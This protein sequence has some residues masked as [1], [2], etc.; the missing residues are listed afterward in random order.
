MALQKRISTPCCAVL[1]HVDVGKTKLLDLMRRTTTSEASGITQ[2]IGTTLYS[3]ERIE[4]LVGDNLKA[5]IGI[6]A[7]LMIDTPGHECFDTIRYVALMVSDVVILMIDMIKGLEKQTIHV[8]SLLQKHNVPFIICVNKMDRIYGWIKPNIDIINVDNNNNNNVNDELIFPLNLANVIKRMTKA[9]VK[10]RYDDYIKKI[11]NKLY[12]YD[13]IS[14]LYY[15]N[16][17]PQDT[18]NIVPISAETGEGVPD[19]VMLISAMAERKYFLD[20]MIESNITYGYILDTHYDKTHGQY[21]VALH[22]NGTINRGDI[23]K[24]N[25]RNYKIK[26]ILTNTDNREIKD[27]HKFVRSK[28]IDISIGIGLVLERLFNDYD[29]SI[30][31]N[32]DNNNVDD[33]VNN[34]D[35]NVDDIDGDIE[36]ASVYTLFSDSSNLSNQIIQLNQSVPIQI[37]NHDSS[38]IRIISS[39]KEYEKRWESYMCE[40]N[41]PGIQ[42]VAPSYVMMDGLLHLLSMLELDK[43]E[44]I[45]DNKD[46]CIVKNKNNGKNNSNSNKFGKGIDDVLIQIQ[47]VKIER[48]KVGRIDKKDIMISSKWIDKMYYYNNVNNNVNDHNHCDS[49]NISFKIVDKKKIKI[50]NKLEAQRYALIL[51]YDPSNESLPKEILELAKSF[52]VIIL[53]SNVVYRLIDLYD[54]HLSEIHKQLESIEKHVKSVVQVIPKYVFRTSKPM[55]IGVQ[56]LKGSLKVKHEIYAD[57]DLNVK[58]GIIESIQKS[59]RDIEEANINDEVCVKI[60]TT[61][62]IDKDI[63]RNALLWSA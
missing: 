63:T 17:S 45:C 30:N 9:N 44:N 47:K 58:V 25:N 26:F 56:I 36:P 11:Q 39:K 40:N 53:H 62:Q 27:D 13:V 23:I 12:E 59:N 29:I 6:D 57:E 2:Q 5:K 4:K 33:I 55:I 42:V 14:E 50:R 37:P 22:R 35:N 24:I 28:S 19:L 32:D 7:L 21:F 16:R 10:H 52:G 48:Y 41:E 46:D 8:I 60:N 49:E 43:S 15:Q 3:R 18:I 20:R 51:S 38:T 31:N 54:Q 34:V 61:M 1:G